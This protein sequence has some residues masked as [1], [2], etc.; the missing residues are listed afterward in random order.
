[1][2]KKN[3]YILTIAGFDPSGGAGILADVKTF[4]Q[5]KCIG[6]AVQTANTIQTEDEFLS[7]NWVNED[8]VIKQLE[9]LLIKY[10]FVV[11][12]S[13]NS[14]ILLLLCSKIVNITF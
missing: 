10:T 12:I 2:S 3:N 14:Y 7:V 11:E 1:M 5:N 13:A 6:M 8:I 4:E 9:K